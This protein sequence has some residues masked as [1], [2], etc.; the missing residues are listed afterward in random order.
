MPAQTGYMICASAR[1][2]P[3]NH[4]KTTIV[5]VLEQRLKPFGMAL[6]A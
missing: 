6:I 1:P 2:I 3:A 4:A 5:D